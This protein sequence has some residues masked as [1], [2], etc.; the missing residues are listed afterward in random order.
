M[1]KQAHFGVMVP[2]IKRTW[3]Q[4]EA[5]AVEFEE[6]G[7]D[8]IWAN[9]HLYGPQA[10]QIPML[11]AWPLIAALAAKTERVEIGTLVT[12]AGMRNP[13][14]LGKTIATVD[15]IAGGRIIPGLGAGW[16]PGEY[17][18]F[19]MPFG[20]PAERIR[21]LRET[22]ALLKAMW[23]SDEPVTM[24]GDFVNATNLVTE[25]KPS[26]VPPLLIGG[27]GRKGTLPLAAQEATIWNNPAGSQGGLAESIEAL[28]A[29]MDRVDRDHD[30]VTISQQCLVAIAPNEDEAGPMIELAQRIFGGHMGDPT[31]P[32]A[33]TGTP[34]RVVA[35]IGKHV[36]LGCTMFV[37]EFFGTDTRVPARLFAESVM[38][39]FD[40][41]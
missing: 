19:G 10:P 1:T 7:F 8:S 37:I 28:H 27:T 6:L 23:S 35:Q 9:D 16:M 34:E 21:Q 39:H 11:E 4:S 18:D 3:E 5:A 41:G 36:D 22:V 31:G 2:Q 33:I 32:L 40:R 12:P 15:H 29:A 17:T 14:H 26:R 24:H 13:Q 20:S 25:P 30:E 38:P